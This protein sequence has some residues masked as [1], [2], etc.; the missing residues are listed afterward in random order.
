MSSLSLELKYFFFLSLGVSK[1]LR[2]GTGKIGMCL[3]P[4]KLGLV[5]GL[6]VKQSVNYLNNNAYGL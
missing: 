4:N 5:Y 3:L 2:S 1:I 6:K